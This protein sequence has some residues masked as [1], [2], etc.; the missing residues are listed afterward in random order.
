M[1]RTFPVTV[2][3]G[4][5]VQSASTVPIEVGEQVHPRATAS[6]LP[7]S[8]MTG[9]ISHQHTSCADHRRFFR[10]SK[11]FRKRVRWRVA[12]A[13]FKLG[14]ERAQR[15]NARRP[16]GLKSADNEI[17]TAVVATSQPARDPLIVRPA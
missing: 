10:G 4:L 1:D 16:A 6:R 14:A 11:W 12:V 5:T 17:F 8:F 7:G 9:L 15:P 13:W 2:E 3:E